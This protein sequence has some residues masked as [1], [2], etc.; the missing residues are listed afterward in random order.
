MIG[1]GLIAYAA[2]FRLD[3]SFLVIDATEPDWTPER[4]IA[5]QFSQGKMP[6]FE[7]VRRYLISRG[8]DRDRIEAEGFGE[9]RPIAPASRHRDRRRDRDRRSRARR[10]ARSGRSCGQTS[11]RP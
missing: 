5:A 9:A 1:G 7:S 10:R 11:S 8:I 3:V 6:Y 4:R 2:S